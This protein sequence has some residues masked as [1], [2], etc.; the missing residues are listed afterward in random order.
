MPSYFRS[1]I[2]TLPNPTTVKTV[3][4]NIR[5]NAV[6]ID[7]TIKRLQEAAKLCKTE[8]EKVMLQLWKDL[9]ISTGLQYDKDADKIVGFEDF[10]N[11][12]SE[13]FADHELGF[14]LCSV[15]SGDNLPICFSFCDSQ[16][17]SIQLQSCIRVVVNAVKDDSFQVSTSSSKIER[18]VS[19][20][21]EIPKIL[22]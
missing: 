13:Q 18:I 11:V 12:R 1:I 7:A 9:L 19:N 15:Q 2:A 6:V 21:Q 22:F 20:V 10:G 14:M 17:K 4:N 5:M 16:T 8:Q 3:L